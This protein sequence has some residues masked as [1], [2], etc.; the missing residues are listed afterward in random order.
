MEKERGER[1]SLYERWMRL[2]QE[3]Y[4]RQ[5][6][7][8]EA[9]ESAENRGRLGKWNYSFGSFSQSLL[10]ARMSLGYGKLFV[11]YFLPFVL[12]PVFKWTGVMGKFWGLLSGIES[13]LDSWS[14]NMLGDSVQTSTVNVADGTGRLLGGLVNVIDPVAV[15]CWVLTAYIVYCIIWRKDYR[16]VWHPEMYFG[17][18]LGYYVSNFYIRVIERLEGWFGSFSILGYG[19]ILEL[20]AKLVQTY[21]D[22]LCQ[23]FLK[24]GFDVRLSLRQLAQGLYAKGIDVRNLLNVPSKTIAMFIILY[25]VSNWVAVI[26]QQIW[27]LAE[28][29]SVTDVPEKKDGEDINREKVEVELGR[30]VNLSRDRAIPRNVK[31]FLCRNEANFQL[32]RKCVFVDRDANTGVML[33][34]MGHVAHKDAFAMSFMS[35]A[36]Y[37]FPLLVWLISLPFS[38][39]PGVNAITG[40]ATVLVNLAGTLT[41]RL[42]MFI[43]TPIQRIYETAADMYTLHYRREDELEGFLEIEDNEGWKAFVDPHPKSSKRVRRL[44]RVSRWLDEKKI[45]R[46]IDRTCPD[47]KQTYC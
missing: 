17:M 44:E 45:K 19:S 10:N 2:K 13:S 18:F 21:R 5:I 47:F 27:T 39:I 14:Y 29:Y 34:E 9:R 33:H 20:P 40:L 6:E 7:R 22:F 30:R 41:I 12:I 1:R 24:M 3:R 11:I 15:L 26:G 37:A 23:L 43:T 46:W 32:S 38:V 28:T 4:E 35:P 36:A 8:E 16:L 31:L 42:Y 25:F